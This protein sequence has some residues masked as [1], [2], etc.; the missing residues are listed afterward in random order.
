MVGVC[1]DSDFGGLGVLVGVGKG[2]GDHVGAVG[3]VPTPRV[4]MMM[5]MEEKW[6][7]ERS[8]K[9][10]AEAQAATLRAYKDR[11]ANAH[12]RAASGNHGAA[13]GESGM[14]HEAT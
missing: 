14:S 13:C 5:M 6:R 2:F 7:G 10:G 3:E 12:H 4:K 8:V 11:T 1:A 9:T